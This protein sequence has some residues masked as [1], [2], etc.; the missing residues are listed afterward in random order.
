MGNRWTSKH[1]V[2]PDHINMSQLDTAV[3]LYYSNT[4]AMIKLR[5]SKRLAKVPNGVFRCILEY[6]FP[7]V[8]CWRYA[9][10]YV[11]IKWQ[12]NRHFPAV[13]KLDYNNYL[14]AI[15]EIL[16]CEY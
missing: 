4:L 2:V 8:L 9:E 10:P 13:D 6:Q 14:V 16:L 12:Q 7:K 11:P 5:K 1:D 15:N 3:D